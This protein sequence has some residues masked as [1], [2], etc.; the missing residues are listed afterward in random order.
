MKADYREKM[1]NKAALIHKE[2]EERRAIIEARLKEDF[3]N[4]EEMASKYRVTG[5]PSKKRFGCF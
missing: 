2:A 1:N 5:F 4:I 3:L